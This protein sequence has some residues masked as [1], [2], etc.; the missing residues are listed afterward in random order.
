M[1]HH[2]YH[3]AEG[4]NASMFEALNKMPFVGTKDLHGVNFPFYIIVKTT[5][6]LLM[7]EIWDATANATTDKAADYKVGD[8]IKIVSI[9]QDGKVKTD[10]LMLITDDGKAIYGE[11]L[12]TDNITFSASPTVA[13]STT[14]VIPV[15]APPTT[16]P[17][18]TKGVV[19]AGAG[20]GLLYAFNKKKGLFGFALYAAAGALIF[21]APYNYYEKF[22]D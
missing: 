16:V 11:G 17:S 7:P 15:S 9:L 4:S 5:D 8:I 19:Y 12:K 18:W 21:S 22:K 6:N 1:H 13:S 2:K 20:L 14:P 3:S 10:S